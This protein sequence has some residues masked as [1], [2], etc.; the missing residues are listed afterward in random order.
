MS[1]QHYNNIYSKLVLSEDDVEGMIAYCTYKR[2]KIEFITEYKEQHDGVSPS[3]QDMD[4][5]FISSVTDSQLEKYRESAG[6]MLLETVTSVAGDEVKMYED[7]MLRDYQK[8]IKKCLPSTWRTI[9]LNIVATFLFSVLLAIIY[10]VLH[11][12]ETKTKECVDQLIKTEKTTPMC[13]ESDSIFVS[14]Q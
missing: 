1:K 5:F 4:N 9:A 12:S 10:F 7:E 6:N 13:V 8:H 14:H 3:D 2:H 11:T